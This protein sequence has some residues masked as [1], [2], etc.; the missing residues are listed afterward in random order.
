MSEGV[1]C[2]VFFSG[3]REGKADGPG[4]TLTTSLKVGYRP[5]LLPSA[6]NGVWRDVWFPNRLPVAKGTGL[7]APL[8]LL[9]GCGLCEQSQGK[10]ALPTPLAILPWGPEHGLD[11][12][13]LWWHTAALET[14]HFYRS[15]VTTVLP[16]LSL[17]EY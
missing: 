3:A 2:F 7:R 10:P 11:P 15:Y 9:P 4:R 5:S 17:R 6:H 12:M 16:R 1:H 13:T 14:F 8:H